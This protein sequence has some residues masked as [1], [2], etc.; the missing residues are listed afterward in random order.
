MDFVFSWPTGEFAIMGA[1]Q[2]SALLYRKE[3]Q[4]AKD[5]EAALKEKVD[6][7]RERFVN[8]YYYAASMNVDDVIAPA[9]TRRRVISGF[10]LLEGKVEARKEC[11]HGNMPL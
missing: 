8:P 7:Y 11:R 10:K 5:A 9:E 6:E 3:I 2:A 4:E 1:E